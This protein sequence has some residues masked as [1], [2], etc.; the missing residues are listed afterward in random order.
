MSKKICG[1]A[2]RRWAVFFFGMLL[3]SI[4]GGLIGGL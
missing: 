4:L 2:S 3:G 1:F